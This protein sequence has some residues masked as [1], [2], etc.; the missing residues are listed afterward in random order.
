MRHGSGSIQSSV[1][2]LE[3]IGRSFPY[4]IAGGF[5]F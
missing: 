1:L 2:L 4:A 3:L 5:F